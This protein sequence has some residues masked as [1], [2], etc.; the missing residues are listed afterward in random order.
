MKSGQLFNQSKVLPKTQTEAGSNGNLL[1]G[2][3]DTIN[4]KISNPNYISS[5]KSSV[6]KSVLQVFQSLSNFKGNMLSLK[7]KDNP[8]TFILKNLTMHGNSVCSESQQE[9]LQN[10]TFFNL[11]NMVNL[12]APNEVLDNLYHRC[13][14]MFKANSLA[15][16]NSQSVIKD[17]YEDISLVFAKT[18]MNNRN[19]S[20]TSKQKELIS[21]LSGGGYENISKILRN[22]DQPKQPISKQSSSSNNKIPIMC[23]KL[24][25][26][27]EQMKE[28]RASF[29]EI[30][31]LPKYRETLI[32]LQK[33]LDQLPKIQV[34][35]RE[36]I[37]LGTGSGHFNSNQASTKSMSQILSTQTGHQTREKQSCCAEYKSDSPERQILPMNLIE[38]TEYHQ[39]PHMR[40][41]SDFECLSPT[42][43]KMKQEFDQETSQSLVN[44]L[45]NFQSE[46]TIKEK[47]ESAEQSKD[48]TEK[49]AHLEHRKELKEHFSSN[50]KKSRKK[51]YSNYKSTSKKA[52]TRKSFSTQKKTVRAAKTKSRSPATLKRKKHA[53]VKMD[54]K[55]SLWKNEKK[56][57]ARNV[58]HLVSLMKNQDY[59]KMNIKNLKKAFLSRNVFNY[60]TTQ[61]KRFK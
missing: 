6:D 24:K 39:M 16:E 23:E 25:K 8:S 26:Q 9:S 10:N 44:P 33:Y 58:R 29:V 18:S 55:N 59:S 35:E 48:R 61:L 36:V 43:K 28:F 3:K 51:R 38:K 17:E 30:K 42:S 37:K 31:N 12:N 32:E 49:K 53:S 34:K 27:L 21:K 41:I 4:P 15:K 57:K 5:R 7:R 20:G 46:T 50:K 22:L 45:V 56:P 54:I 1:P 60:T 2:K 11:D 13:P 47:K 14:K 19:E 52:T 40:E